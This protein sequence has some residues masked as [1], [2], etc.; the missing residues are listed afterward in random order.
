MLA[1]LSHTHTGRFGRTELSDTSAFV[2]LPDGKVVSGTDWGNLLLWEGGLIKCEI[3]R[4][5]RKNCHNGPVE[6][7]IIEENEIISAGADG[8]I[9][10]RKIFSR[11]FFF[12]QLCIFCYF[13]IN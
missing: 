13:I 8:H 3:V 9:R 1:P 11:C 7:V 10:V 5:G 12:C 6:C 2:E 4:K